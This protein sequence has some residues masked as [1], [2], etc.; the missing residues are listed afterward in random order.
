MREVHGLTA[1]PMCDTLHRRV[2]LKD[3]QRARCRVCGSELARSSRLNRARMIPLVLTCLLLFV[4]ANV[5]PIVAIELQG[6]VHQLTLVGA[7]MTLLQSEMFA[8]ALMVFVP[9][10][11][12]PGLYLLTLLFV[13]W[14]TGRGDVP[15][16]VQNRLV[17]MMQQ[18]YPWSMVE[19]FL[20][21][22]LVAIIKLSSMASIIAGPALWAWMGTTI[23]LTVV[24]TFRLRR[25]IRRTHM[26]VGE[27][28]LQ[29]D[30][31]VYAGQP[32]VLEEA[33]GEWKL[34]VGRH[35]DAHDGALLTAAES[36]RFCGR[37]LGMIALCAT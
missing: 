22:V 37:R 16:G 25:L 18:V 3:G 21:G 17:R 34:A 31:V 1:C 33:D 29:D 36:A 6:T 8:V 24:L 26:P 32:P 11:F 15:A 5:F 12:L 28:R 9:T 4:M 30:Q 7:V 2:H 10:L 14:L 23:T 13:L 35:R 20:L 27:V 19:V